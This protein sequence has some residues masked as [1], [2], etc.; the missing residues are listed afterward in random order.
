M[1]RIFIIGGGRLAENLVEAFKNTDSVISGIYA[2]SPDQL[3]KIVQENNIAGFNDLESIPTDCDV[4]FIAVSDKSIELVSKQINPNGLVVHC[5]GVLPI[6]ALNK[7]LNVGVFWPI[8]TLS[9]NKKIDFQN[10]PIC[11]ESN[12]ENNRKLLVK[13]A[14][15]ISSKSVVVN[16]EER[17][18]LH[19]SAVLVNNFSNHLYVLAKQYLEE[20]ELSFDLLKPLILQTTE[21]ALE[22]DP[23]LVQTGPASRKDFGTI[24]NHETL[25]IDHPELLNIYKSLTQSILHQSN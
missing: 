2:R 12:S 8:Q 9:L 4:Y 11:I 10:V 18:K 21:N 19:L 20:N 15:K 13:L 22:K 17:R 6:G 24:T 7:H 5:S 3:K 23:T 1:I 14:S 16:S 25:L